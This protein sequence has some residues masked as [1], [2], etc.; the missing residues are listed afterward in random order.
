MMLTIKTPNAKFNGSRMGI[1][2]RQGE[3]TVA[4]LSE[5][6]VATFHKWGYSIKG[7]EA[8]AK[9]PKEAE[10]SESEKKPEDSGQASSPTLDASQPSKE[11]T[12]T[13]EQPN[14]SKK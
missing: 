10:Q 14:S 3:A 9:K 12:A 13:E 2:F 4:E 8:K 7:L 11:A 1:V 6:Q 5:V